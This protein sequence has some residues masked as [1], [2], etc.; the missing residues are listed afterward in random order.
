MNK[1]FYLSILLAAIVFIEIDA[2]TYT[3]FFDSVFA[4]ISKSEATTGILYE[5]VIPISNAASFNSQTNLVDT[6]NTSIF[7]QCYYELY[8]STFD[9]SLSFLPNINKIKEEARTDSIIDIGLLHCRLNVID[10]AV[11]RQ[12]LYFDSDSIL[13]E[14]VNITQS[15]YLEKEIFIASPFTEYVYTGK[16]TFFFSDKFLFDNTNKVISHININFDDGMGVRQIQPN[17]SIDVNYS[18]TGEHIVSIQLVFENGQILDSYSFLYC[19]SPKAKNSHPQ[20]TITVTADIPFTDY[21]NYSTYGTGCMRVYYANSDKILRKPILILDGFDPKNSRNFETNTEPTEPSLWDL[22]YY[23]ND[24]DSIHIGDILI[25][26]YGYDL[27]F[28]D[29]DKGGDYIERNAMVCVKALKIIND[30]LSSTESNEQIILIG[31]SMGGQIARFAL[32]YMEQNPSDLNTNYGVHNTRL[33]IS[34]DSPHQGANIS[35]GAQALMYYYGNVGNFENAADSWNNLLN[36]PAAKQMLIYQFNTMLPPTTIFQTCSLS[37]N[38]YTPNSYFSTFYNKMHTMGYP[39]SRNIAITNGS[40]NGVTNNIG[41]SD[42][43]DIRIEFGNIRLSKIQLFPTNHHCEIFYGMCPVGNSDNMIINFLFGQK[44]K[45]YVFANSLNNY[46]IDAAPGGKYKTFDIIHSAFKKNMGKKLKDETMNI[47]THCFMP[48]TSTLDISGNMNY[49]TNIASRNLVTEGLTPFDSYAGVL[50]SNMY[51]V[52]FN[53]QLVDYMLNEIETY[54]QGER[55]IQLCTRPTYTLHLPQDSTATITWISSNNIKIIPTSNS[56]Q[57]TIIPLSEGEAWISAEV[58][59]LKHRKRLANYPIQ[60]SINENNTLPIIHATTIRGQS[61]SINNEVLLADTFCIENGKTLTITGILHCSPATRII[62]R[63]GGKLVVDGGVLTSACAGEMWQ[64]VEVI[65]N[66]ELSQNILNQ[67]KIEIKN[68][69]IIENAYT[70]IRTGESGDNWNTTGGI[71]SA[72]ETTFRNNQR[73]IEFLSYA[74]TLSNGTILNNISYFNN[75]TFIIDTNNIFSQNDCNFTAHI[76]MWDVRGINI[77]GCHFKNFTSG[78]EEKKRAIYAEDA[79][80]HI[81]KICAEDTYSSVTCTCSDNSSIFSEFTGFST[82]IELF[83][84]G[85]QYAVSVDFSKFTNN[86]NAITINGNNF[87]SITRCNF[88]LQNTPTMSLTNRGILLNNCT[89]YK[90]EENSFYRDSPNQAQIGS[91]GIWIQNSGS[92]YN[93]LYRNNFSNLKYG[94]YAIGNNGNT[95]GGLQIECSSFSYNDYDI[96]LP[97]R[98]SI[99]PWQGSSSQG[100]DNTFIGTHNSS[101]YNASSQQ[102]TYFHSNSSHIMNPYNVTNN[103]F[104]S[105]TALANNCISTLCNNSSK[106]QDLTSLNPFNSIQYDLE[107]NNSSFPFQLNNSSQSSTDSLATFVELSKIYIENILS[108]MNTFA[109]NLQSLARWHSSASQFANCYSIAETQFQSDGVSSYVET[110]NSEETI[111]YAN[112]QMLKT[113]CFNNYK[114]NWNELTDAQITI[115][116]EIADQNTGRSSEIAKGILCFFFN[117]CYENNE[118]E[119]DIDTEMRRYQQSNCNINSTLHIYPNPSNDNLYIEHSEFISEISIYDMQGR[120]VFF[121]KVES[122]KNSVHII[123]NNLSSGIYLIKVTNNINNTLYQKVIKK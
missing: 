28:L 21:A 34:L 2:Q 68:G 5:R 109:I 6:I 111:N 22:L 40:I 47:H 36:C 67:G 18:R 66:R 17:T 101:F 50:D 78:H 84:T 115:L 60:I 77:N 32:T 100:A 39:S 106:N 71:I 92:G 45:M 43:I 53:Q 7:L 55:N 117:I 118:S 46:S 123:L 82:A 122:Q 88:N 29:F 54:I 19:Y 25:D 116:Q 20:E 103:I 23:T 105:N 31:P 56:T 8:S 16:T 62:I 94:V 79:G 65:G 113:L 42:A 13:R 76:T 80:F 107:N 51:H 10:T 104:V 90:I 61:M 24:E 57:I 120:K 15:L 112:L 89:G 41:C 3:Q 81:S 121:K 12:K 35:L 119:I 63:P 30:K 49:C 73:S 4:H 75:C 74:D 72:S 99:A 96:Y 85:N 38:Q 108:E 83:T 98:A 91:T 87:V 27:I 9:T 33:W 48:I 97:Q 37:V 102:I 69:A 26:N 114:G 44:T 52:T 64:G 59:T 11:S 70:G 14:K 93:F 95:N 1:K 58:S 86:E 110:E